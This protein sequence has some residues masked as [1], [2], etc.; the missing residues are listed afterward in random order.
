MGGVVA[1]TSKYTVKVDDLLEVAKESFEKFRQTSS[2]DVTAWLDLLR[3]CRQP[4]ILWEV[5]Y[6]EPKE[7]LAGIN[8]LVRQTEDILYENGHIVMRPEFSADMSQQIAFCTIRAHLLS[9]TDPEASKKLFSDMMDYFYGD[10]TLIRKSNLLYH[11]CLAFLCC[12]DF[13]KSYDCFERHWGLLKYASPSDRIKEGIVDNQTILQI[14][15]WFFIKHVDDF[16]DFYAVRSK[17]EM[18]Q[19][20][21]HKKISFLYFMEYDCSWVTSC[22]GLP[23]YQHARATYPALPKYERKRSTPTN[24]CKRW[25]PNDVTI[26]AEETSATGKEKYYFEQ[27]NR[28][29]DLSRKFPNPDKADDYLYSYYH[30]QNDYVEDFNNKVLLSEYTRENIPMWNDDSLVTTVLELGCGVEIPGGFG[31]KEYLGVDISEKVCDVLEEQNNVKYVHSPADKFLIETDS[32]FDLCFACDLLSNLQ[33]QRLSILLKSCSEKCEYFVALID[34]RDD[35]RSDILSKQLRVEN[36]NLHR[37]VRTHEE[38][39]QMLESHF[40]V[41]HKIEGPWLYVFCKSIRT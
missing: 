39:V 7:E 6:I 41:T 32:R 37:T 36:I 35:I 13:A 11:A 29:I 19:V 23:F 34:T 28:E 1:S 24:V 2:G 15:Y 30:Y 8:D 3:T 16:R 31:A 12:N 25:H 22:C 5:D 4:Q 40:E 26:Y 21:N 27:Y 33:P 17:V 20:W 38:W 14:I 10:L 9:E 18:E